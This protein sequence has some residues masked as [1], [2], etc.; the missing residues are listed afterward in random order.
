M[1]HRI[2]RQSRV[3]I[4]CD[5]VVVLTVVACIVAEWLQSGR[6]ALGRI[7]PPTIEL[8]V[9]SAF[10]GIVIALLAF[11]TTCVAFRRFRS[12][13]HRQTTYAILVIL[14]IA[15]SLLSPS[16]SEEVRE[17]GYRWMVESGLFVLAVAI[18]LIATPTLFRWW[19]HWH[20][21]IARASGPEPG[22]MV[23]ELML[24]TALFAVVLAGIGWLNRLP[25]N[26][27]MFSGLRKALIWAVMI[28]FAV[29]S[30]VAGVFASITVRWSLQDFRKKGSIIRAFVIIHLVLMAVIAAFQ[31]FRFNDD[32]AIQ[33]TAWTAFVLTSMAL[34]FLL[35]KLGLRFYVGY[36]PTVDQ[37]VAIDIATGIATDVGTG[38]GPVR[39]PQT[40]PTATG[41]AGSA[42]R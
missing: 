1:S 13:L 29:V 18:G 7:V 37:P 34:V 38:L 39:D 41:S 35:R 40:E 20:T 14:C 10:A 36:G 30:L 19:R 22:S 12:I 2:D 23:M 6:F 27:E 31:R 28:S 21:A 25:E 3:F 42:A 15:I 17:N 26:S 9:S 4:G 5:M 32:F 8:L 11:S 24:I 33:S 16:T